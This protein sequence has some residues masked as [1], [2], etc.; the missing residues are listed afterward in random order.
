M[1]ETDVVLVRYGEI[2]VKSTQVRIGMEKRLRE[3]LQKTLDR[4]DVPSNVERKWS[5]IYIHTPETERAVRVASK[6]PGVVSASPSV[7]TTAEEEDVTAT[8]AELASRYYDG[9]SFAIDARRAGDEEQHPYGSEEIAAR[10]GDAVGE[11]VGFEEK[12]DL[13]DPDFTIYLEIR[14]QTCYVYLEKRSGPGG[15]PYG[16][17]TPV[18]ALI[19]GGID[20]P[21]AAWRIMER[22]SPILPLYFDLGKYGGV[23]HM[24]RAK[25]TVSKLADRVP[26]G[27]LELRVVDA[28]ETVDELV[29]RVGETRMLSYRRYM[30]RAA[31][32][33]AREQEA[34]GI[35]TGE[36]VGQKSSQTTRNLQA[37]DSVTELPVHRPLLTVD[38][39]DITAEAKE[40]R[41]FTDSK[42]NVGCNRI[43][44]DRPRTKARLSEVLRAEPQDLLEMAASDAEQAG[45][46]KVAGT[47][48]R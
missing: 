21:V 44:P 8:A 27:E 31:E 45:I 34:A 32:T 26:E 42:M 14:N 43:A 1:K 6:T 39:T 38:K 22:G 47:P 13:D 35:V 19:S 20:S 30:Y 40:I 7:I 12:V 36:A 15:L 23:D 4:K 41:T 2:G 29:N 5:R 46:Q 25:E 17:Q 3:N 28:E 11:S 9:G 33:I 18:V 24:Q 37:T 16:S 48:D 10:A